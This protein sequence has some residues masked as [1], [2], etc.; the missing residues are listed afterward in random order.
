VEQSKTVD[1]ISAKVAERIGNITT[2]KAG[3][4]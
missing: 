3:T 1:L 4:S 2:P